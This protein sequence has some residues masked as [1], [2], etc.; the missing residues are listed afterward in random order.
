M[1]KVQ[2]T[3][4]TEVEVKEG[5]TTKRPTKSPKTPRTKVSK[6]VAQELEQLTNPT[7]ESLNIEIKENEVKENNTKENEMESVKME[8]VKVMMNGE[9][10]VESNEVE[11]VVETPQVEEVQEV[12]EVVGEENESGIL[13][14]DEFAKLT[15]AEQVKL[16]KQYRKDFQVE[17]IKREM[18]HS[19]SSYYALMKRLGLHD[20]IAR[21]LSQPRGSQKTQAKVQA[22]PKEITFDFIQNGVKFEGDLNLETLLEKLEGFIKFGGG[23]ESDFEFKFELIRK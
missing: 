5:K 21:P 19:T 17:Q 1:A 18:G 23:N 9:E 7:Q 10:V 22:Q 14:R 4:T 13:H 20:Q 3:K 16:M 11:E 2:D 15:F 6:E 12:Q 8:N